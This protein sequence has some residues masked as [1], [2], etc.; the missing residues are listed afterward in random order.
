MGG[1]G[2]EVRPL[3]T[4]LSPGIDHLERAILPPAALDGDHAAVRRDS[5]PLPRVPL[6][7]RQLSPL[8]GKAKL[9]RRRSAGD[10]RA[11]GNQAVR[12]APA[13]N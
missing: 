4:L 7:F 8:Q 11:F 13:S 5:V 6:Q 2:M 12:V 10:R 1:R 9:A 3:S